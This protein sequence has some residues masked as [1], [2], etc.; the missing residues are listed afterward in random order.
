[1]KSKIELIHVFMRDKTTTVYRVFYKSGKV[2]EYETKFVFG[3]PE[4]V[5]KFMRAKANK[6]S[7]ADT[8]NGKTVIYYE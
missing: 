2:K 1:M 5:Y 7:L 6:R 4:T 8:A 3:M